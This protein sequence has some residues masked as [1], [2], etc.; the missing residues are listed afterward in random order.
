MLSYLQNHTTVYRPKRSPNFTNA[1][2]II[3]TEE[4]EKRKDIIFSKHNSTVTN[5]AK[6]REW[7]LICTKVNS[8]NSSFS[9]T[10]DDLKKKW[11]VLCSD[12]KKKNSKIK[13]EERKTGGGKLPPDCFVTPVEDNIQSIIGETAISGIDGGIDTLVV[14]KEQSWFI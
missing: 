9:R 2:I 3:L 5:Q 12:T 10:A 8:V 13:R 4:A 1:E 6:K 11:S 14:D 7:D